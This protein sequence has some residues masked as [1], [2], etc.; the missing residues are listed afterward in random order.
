MLIFPAPAK[1]SLHPGTR[2]APL[3]TTPSCQLDKQG[4]PA[5]GFHLSIKNDSILL[6]H[7]DDAGKFYGLQCLEQIRTQ[8]EGTHFPEM[9][10]EDAPQLPVRGF[11]LDIS[12]CRVPTMETLQRLVRLLALARYNQLQLYTEHTFAYSR[13]PL[14]WGDASPL[15][16]E[17]IRELD[18]YCREYNIE[19][20]PN[21]NSFGHF[22]R[23]LRYP[24]YQ[25]LAECPNGFKHP[26]GAFRPIGT[27]L[28]PTDESLALVSELYDELLPNFTSN[29]F[30]VGG[31]EPWE[32]GQGFSK[33]RVEK[34]GKHAVYLEFMNRIFKMVSSR[35]KTTQFWADIILEAPD[36]LDQV[37]QDTIPIIWGYEDDHPFE[38]QCSQVAEAGFSQFLVAPGTATWNSLTCRWN[39]ARENIRSAVQSSIRHGAQG[40]LNT[41]WGDQG[42]HY[43]WIFMLAPLLAGGAMA[44]NPDTFSEEALM[45]VL[46]RYVFQDNTGHLSRALIQVGGI[47]PRFGKKLFNNSY[48]FAAL[49]YDDSRV[50][51][52]FSD[53]R[54]ENLKEI[55]AFLKTQREAVLAA[56]PLSD[57]ADWLREEALLGIDLSLAGLA[58]AIHLIHPEQPALNRG[59]MRSLIGRFENNWLQRSRPGGML[60]SSRRLRRPYFPEDVPVPGSV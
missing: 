18:A 37:P 13:H 40:I 54:L 39:I 52:I 9:E 28:R 1:Q 46:N 14:V 24:E 25:H 53:A 21:Q 50:R 3:D 10:I 56:N 43:E 60:E 35:G 55:E 15:T 22:E 59:W 41:S 16:G 48:L 42:H 51:E 49:V 36:K 29:L 20:V 58:R 5:E 7:S 32:L 12:R 34:E 23:W 26:G 33:E 44:W 31:D 17:E 4:V 19:L 27:T 57:D 11:M 2:G 47:E 8:C 30:N 38:K 45:E 6:R